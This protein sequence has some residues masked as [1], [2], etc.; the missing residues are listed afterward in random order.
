MYRGKSSSLR[1]RRR[2]QTAL[3]IQLATLDLI[4]S[5]GL[6]DVTTEMIAQRAGISA[7]TFFNYYAN[8]ESAAVGNPPE[9]SPEAVNRFLAETGPLSAGIVGLLRDQVIMLAEQRDA[10][11]RLFSVLRANPQLLILLDE[12]LHRLWGSLA[13]L[14][15]QRLG[16]GREGEAALLADL[17][18]AAVRNTM[19]MWVRDDIREIDKVVETVITRLRHVGKLLADL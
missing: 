10:I 9:F 11:D 16:P 2:R 5:H 17:L 14:L 6:A 19:R 8:K 18:L 3:D 13:N 1:E 15:Q 7:R 4:T 12:N